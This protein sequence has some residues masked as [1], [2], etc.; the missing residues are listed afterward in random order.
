MWEWTWTISNCSNQ[1]TAAPQPIA[2][3]ILGVPVSNIACPSWKV[4]PFVLTVLIIDPPVINGPI[5]SI[6][7]FFTRR[8]PIPV[9]P[10]ILWAETA[11]KSTPES[12]K[13]ILSWGAPWAQSSSTLALLEWDISTILSIGFLIPRTLL[14]WTTHTRAAPSTATSNACMSKVNELVSIGTYL[15]SIPFSL[16]SCCHGTISAWCSISVMTTTS[17]S[18][19]FSLAQP[20]ETRFMASVAPLV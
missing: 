4:D 16:E 15:T 19:R 13:L 14:V 1:S 3:A 17:S 2:S 20:N 11:T 5:W 6:A 8:H 12:S 7:S 10:P 9:G 18:S